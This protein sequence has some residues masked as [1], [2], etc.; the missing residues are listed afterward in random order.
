LDTRCPH[1]LNE[2]QFRYIGTPKRRN[3]IVAGT[4]TLSCHH[5]NGGLMLNVHPNEGD[6]PFRLTGEVAVLAIAL[7]AWLLAQL[8]SPLLP[9][10]PT[11][12]VLVVVG[13]V[14]LVAHQVHFYKVT[15]ASWPRYK[16]GSLRFIEQVVPHL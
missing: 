3:A 12:A 2:L 1:C 10:G 14:G 11:T 16:A 5:C 7:A 15:L 8:F 9:P 6:L 13:I 4:A